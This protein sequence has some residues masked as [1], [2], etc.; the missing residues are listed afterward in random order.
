MG[1]Q[2]P[3]IPCLMT[4]TVLQI[5]GRKKQDGSKKFMK[6]NG[7]RIARDI[8]YLSL[9]EPPLRPPISDACDHRPAG[10]TEYK[11]RDIKTSKGSWQ[12]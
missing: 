5:R 8:S 4:K 7:Y 11:G 1:P 12:E 3:K 9:T 10:A 2:I 6:Q